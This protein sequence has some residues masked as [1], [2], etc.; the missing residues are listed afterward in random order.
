VAGSAR[1]PIRKEVTAGKTQAG[2]IGGGYETY[3]LPSA[4][5]G[6][7]PRGRI[8]IFGKRANGLKEKVHPASLRFGRKESRVLHEINIKPYILGIQRRWKRRR[9]TR[10]A[11]RSGK[12]ILFC[13][14]KK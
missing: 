1:P 6:E 13:Q 2:L 11:P 7:G 4:P 8:E 3:R 10:T 5:E 12:D 14:D 9:S